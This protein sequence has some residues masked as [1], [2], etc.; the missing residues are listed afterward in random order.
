MELKDKQV[1][2]TGANGFIGS[3]LVEMLLDKG[4]KVFA[5]LNNPKQLG[6]LEEIARLDEIH[7]VFGD[8]KNLEEVKVVSKGKEFIF[9]LAGL[10][11]VTD[12]YNN[13]N[14][15]FETNCIGTFN[16]LCAAK[17]AGTKKMIIT[18][19]AEVYRE[20]EYIPVDEKH[21]VHPNSPYS[22]SKLVADN[23]AMEFN[24]NYSLPITI[25]R[26]FNVYGPR[27]ST[28]PLI[29]AVINGLLKEEK[30]KLTNLSTGR[31][32]VYVKD[33]VSALIKMAESETTNYQIFNIGSG[34]TYSIGEVFD[35]S[36][37]ILG[38]ERFSNVEISNEFE[39]AKRE[40]VCNN[41]AAKKELG[42]EPKYS[43]NDGL[44]E[45]IEYFKKKATKN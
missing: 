21:P 1:L 7:L 43:F 19:S 5:L 45:T 33:V 4:A 8:V 32:F 35:I 25:A 18:S 16:V 24:K 10:N 12:S 38:K 29:P 39:R 41:F 13:Q 36:K 15:F 28:K 44:I 17:E 20:A 31:D 37:T 34:Q 23:I 30:I 11:S 14:A 2:V 26:L 6:K 3:H 9:H 40:L 42:W 27:Q 22:I